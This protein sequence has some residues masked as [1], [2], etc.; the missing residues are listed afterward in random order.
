MLKLGTERVE[1]SPLPC[2]SNA[3]P[4]RDAP[5]Y[6]NLDLHVQGSCPHPGHKPFASL[7]STLGGRRIPESQCGCKQPGQRS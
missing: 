2:Q 4:L 1:L 5:I 7:S 3:L 6:Y